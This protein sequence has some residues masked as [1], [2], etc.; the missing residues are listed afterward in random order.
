MKRE[1]GRKEDEGELFSL[2]PSVRR[3]PASVR[4]SGSPLCDQLDCGEDDDHR[5]REER[6][7]DARQK[8]RAGKNERARRRAEAAKERVSG[9]S[10]GGPTDRTHL[11]CC[12]PRRPD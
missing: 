9:G 8:C 5:I 1:G 7:A 11:L 6:N 12:P 10:G 4:P 2:T 3:P